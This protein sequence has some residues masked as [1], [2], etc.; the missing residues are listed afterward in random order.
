MKI[1]MMT[2]RAEE[3]MAQMVQGMEEMVECLVSKCS[4]YS[5]L[6]G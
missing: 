2:P 1:Q 3:T 4:L 6:S 5:V